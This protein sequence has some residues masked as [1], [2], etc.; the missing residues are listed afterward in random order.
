MKTHQY[1]PDRY[2]I[3]NLLAIKNQHLDEVI[4]DIS[5]CSSLLMTESPNY[6]KKLHEKFI[7]ESTSVEKEISK[8]NICL[9]MVAA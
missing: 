2:K 6:D 4:K 1:T 9:R 8:L 3:A 5:A 7:A